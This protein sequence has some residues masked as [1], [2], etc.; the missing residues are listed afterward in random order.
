MSFSLNTKCMNIQK[1]ISL[2]LVFCLGTVLS[3]FRQNNY[4]ISGE[5]KDSKSGEILIDAVVFPSK[6]LSKAVST[7]AYGF[8]S[9]SLSKGEYAI[10]IQL[11]GYEKKTLP[12]L[13]NQNPRLSIKQNTITI[14]LEEVTINATRQNQNIV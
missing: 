8:F 14:D 4:T 11:V 12:I 6:Q 2:M 13:L 3:V 1:T 9:L 7:N 10:T 5:V